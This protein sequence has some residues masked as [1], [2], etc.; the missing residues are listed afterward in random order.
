[1]L[2]REILALVRAKLV[3]SSY[4]N[5]SFK[6]FC[7]Q[8]SFSISVWKHQVREVEENVL[9]Q[10]QLYHYTRADDFDGFATNQSSKRANSYPLKTA[11]LP[12]FASK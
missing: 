7:F 11:W 10:H 5:S 8:F 3:S 4:L 2:A 1:M 9:V 6:F 12:M